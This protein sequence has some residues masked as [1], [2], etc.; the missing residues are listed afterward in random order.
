M[1]SVLQKAIHVFLESSER[2]T[3][4]DLRRFLIEP[5]YRAEF[6]K[7]VRDPVVFGKLDAEGPPGAAGRNRP[8]FR[9]AT[10]QL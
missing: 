7:S 3:L 2:G 9:A 6:L 10:S 4:A 5:P 8:C 1:N